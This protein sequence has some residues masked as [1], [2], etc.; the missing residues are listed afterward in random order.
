MLHN[1]FNK[2]IIT[3]ILK[4]GTFLFQEYLFS[5]REQNFEMR[6]LVPPL[7]PIFFLPYPLYHEGMI[8]GVKGT[9]I[10]VGRVVKKPFTQPYRHTCQHLLP[11]E[12]VILLF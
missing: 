12:E 7:I 8:E 4:N 3:Y 6:T 2:T 9:S 5:L 10:G 1:N 11:Q